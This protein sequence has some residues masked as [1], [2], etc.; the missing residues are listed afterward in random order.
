[1]AKRGGAGDA[2]GTVLCV[3]RHGDAGDALAIPFRDG[4]RPLS[5]KG[6]KQAKRAGKALRR[7]GLLPRDVFTSRLARAA[8]TARA[9]VDAAKGTA[10]VVE[11][12]A[13]APGAE[14]E[15]VVRLLA[16]TPLA[17]SRGDPAAPGPAV[18][19][20]VGHEPGLSRLL[21][22]LVAAQPQGVELK[23]GS[24]AILACG[25]GG[26]DGGSCRLTALL[27]PDAIRD[28]LH[29]GR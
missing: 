23:K 8:E 24:V 17:P 12:A 29:A 6:R 13:L 2:A 14:P 20:V 28:L 9:A 19:W 15:R 7:L 11:T 25:A 18:R 5:E 16:E 3:I 10:H 27:S 22:Y 1:M 21:G 4:L 26:P